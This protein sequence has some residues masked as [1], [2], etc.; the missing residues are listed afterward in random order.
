VS[1]SVTY[2]YSGVSQ[3]A[4]A[5]L[6]K[7]YQCWDGRL[8]KAVLSISIVNM[9]YCTVPSE[10]I[11]RTSYNDWNGRGTMT[12]VCNLFVIMNQGVYKL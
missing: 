1:R 10:D 6:T 8:L 4:P 5:F 3:K 9:F 2:S 7:K 12:Y 11:C